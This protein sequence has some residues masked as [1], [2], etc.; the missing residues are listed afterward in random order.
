VL[1]Y[2]YSLGGL[3]QGGDESWGLPQAFLF[4]GHHVPQDEQFL[5]WAEGPAASTCPGSS[6][7]SSSEDT[8]VVWYPGPP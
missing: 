1:A 4:W 5:P 2:C 3:L 6:C 7:G 8:M